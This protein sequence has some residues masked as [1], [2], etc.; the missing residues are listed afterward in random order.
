MRYELQEVNKNIEIE[1]IRRVEKYL[2]LGA[3]SCILRKEE[4]A[5]IVQ[6]SLLF[7][8]GN[9]FDL[10]AWVVMPNHVH[11]LARFEEGN[12]LPVAIQSLKSY[13]GHQLKKLHP[14]M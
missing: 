1:R 9:H 12:C 3:G 7:H 6:D 11:F 8:H 5:R 2:D 10:K 4:C 13:T 14:E